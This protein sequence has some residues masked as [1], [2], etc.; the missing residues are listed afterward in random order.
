[1]PLSRR[2]FLATTAGWTIA[3]SASAATSEPTRITYE[4]LKLALKPDESYSADKHLVEKVAALDGKPIR[5]RGYILPNVPQLKGIKNFVLIRHSGE[6]CFGPGSTLHDCIDVHMS[7]GTSAKYT[8]F[9]VT[10]EGVFSLKIVTG[11]DGRQLAIY[12]IDAVSV[13]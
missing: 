8:T 5:I 3:I 1:M 10:V 11:A 7:A 6:C 2:L 12:R 4:D 13:R 9:P